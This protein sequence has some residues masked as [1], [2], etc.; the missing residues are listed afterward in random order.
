M[1][2]YL[3]LGSNQGDRRAALTTALDAL[4]QCGVRVSHISPLVESPALL[5]DGAPKEWNL[6]FLNVVAACDTDHAPERVLELGKRIEV[7]LG[8]NNC[9]RW[10]PRPV[11]ID[12]LLW[13]NEQISTE[14]ITIPHPSLHERNFVLTPL[15]ALDPRLT[16]PGLGTNTVLEWSLKLKQH[17]HLW[18]GIVNITPDSFSD[19]GEFLHWEQVDAQ[20]E[21][22]VDAGGQI[23]DLGAESTR[24]GALP[25]RADDEWSR[26]APIL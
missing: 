19:G 6:P 18:M 5:P 20:V 25:L 1:E 13:G 10:S 4:E 24:P 14:A 16:I 17:I 22:M 21:R 12:I 15:I 2:I 8:R 3:G 7:E 26:L 11:D 23:I 9:E